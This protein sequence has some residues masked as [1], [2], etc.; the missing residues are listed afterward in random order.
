MMELGFGFTF[1][2]V[3]GS[4]FTG[5]GFISSCIR[6]SFSFVVASSIF[7]NFIALARASCFRFF[8]MAFKTGTVR[9]TIS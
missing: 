9:L 6:F 1:F 2:F 4:S 8:S 3:M 7:A 5:A